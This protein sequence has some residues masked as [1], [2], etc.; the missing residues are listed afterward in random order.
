MRVF[1]PS[2]LCPLATHQIYPMLEVRSVAHSAVTVRTTQLVK[3]VLH[4]LKDHTGFPVTNP[5]T[6]KIVGI[7]SMKDIFGKSEWATI[8]VRN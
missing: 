4:L 1:S 6:G 7:V 8:E 3:E 5:A 2:L